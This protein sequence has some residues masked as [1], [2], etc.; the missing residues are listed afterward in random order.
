[1]GYIIVGMLFILAA[2]ASSLWTALRRHDPDAENLALPSMPSHV[3]MT[4]EQ[5]DKH[6]FSCYLAGNDAFP[7]N[8]CPF[9]EFTPER[10]Q[11]MA[12]W[13]MAARGKMVDGREKRRT[14]CESSEF[15]KQRP[16]DNS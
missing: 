4:D 11:W 10:E 5:Y 16:A 9:E 7:S 15:P 2:V 14:H 1:M 13:M 8:Y 6:L 3:E 12:G